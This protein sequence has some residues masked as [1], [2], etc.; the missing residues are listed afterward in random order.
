MGKNQ[1]YFSYVCG[2]D[3]QEKRYEDKN[4]R[5]QVAT[6]SGNMVK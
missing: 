3:W 5:P 2:Q 4:K 1:T 6:F